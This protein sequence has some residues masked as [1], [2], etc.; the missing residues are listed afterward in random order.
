MGYNTQQM[1]NA[2]NSFML[3]AARCMEQHP[4]VPGQFQILMV[5]AIVSTALGVELYLK[6]IIGL[7]TGNNQQG[8]KL[9]VLFS[10]QTSTLTKNLPG[11]LL[12]SKSGGTLRK[13]FQKW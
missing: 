13:L 8:H 11:C 9:S 1:L 7:E 12:R 4:I 3:A 10:L 5:P 6:A 2:A